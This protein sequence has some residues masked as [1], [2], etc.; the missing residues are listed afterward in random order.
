VRATT[1]LATI[2][3][4]KKTKVEAV[5]IED[6]IVV[7]ISP[8]ASVPYCAGCLRPVQQVHDERARCWRHLDLAG[9]SLSLRYKLRRVK[10]P[11]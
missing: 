10:C 9:M 2:L 1:L 4:L 7:D 3:G 8:T 11:Q 5:S 6:G